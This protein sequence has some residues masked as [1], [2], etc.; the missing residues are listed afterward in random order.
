MRS[1]SVLRALPVVVALLLV[2]RLAPC[3]NYP[4]LKPAARQVVGPGTTYVHISNDSPQWQ[5]DVVEVDLN[6]PGVRLVPAWRNGSMEKTSVMAGRT[7][8]I[9][10]I[11]A[12][13]FDRNNGASYSHFQIAGRVLSSS[14]TSRPARATFGLSPTRNSPLVLCRLNHRN[15][16]EPPDPTWAT[17]TDAIGGGPLLITSGSLTVTSAAEGFDDASGVNP[18][19]RHPRTALGFNSR[20]R[21]AC[22]VTVDGRQPGWSVG[23]TCTEMAKLLADFGCDQALN[24]DGGGSTTCWVNGRV[25]NRPSDGAER[26]VATAWLIVPTTTR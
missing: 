10:A 4:G 9:A 8:A 19:S 21:R 5:I 23:M 16:P 22:L 17:V 18:D 14:A 13:Y 11:N 25:M 15:Q 26:P 7:G 1:I 24:Y 3:Q 12:G 2:A 20:T 6:N